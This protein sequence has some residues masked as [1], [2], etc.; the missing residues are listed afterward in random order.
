MYTWHYSTINDGSLHL[1]LPLPET[2]RIPD[3]ITPQPVTGYHL[4]LQLSHFSY[5][6]GSAPL[7]IA[8]SS[9]TSTIDTSSPLSTLPQPST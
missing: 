1:R 5:P 4:H 8:F 6:L 9:L 3:L 2:V 7:L